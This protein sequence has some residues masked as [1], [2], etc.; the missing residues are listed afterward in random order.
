MFSAQSAFHPIGTALLCNRHEI[1]PSG[2]R[3][4]QW[5]VPSDSRG[6]PNV[7]VAN[8]GKVLPAK[9]CG[10]V[11]GHGKQWRF[12]SYSISICLQ[13]SISFLFLLVII[14]LESLSTFLLALFCT[15]NLSPDLRRSKACQCS[16]THDICKLRTPVEQ[17]LKLLSGSRCH[18]R[19][20]PDL[21]C[22]E[23]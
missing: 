17:L 9:Y 16:A 10:I 12:L 8:I 21:H 22:W 5:A 14:I 19:H 6:R 1:Q 7:L 4:Q 20:L 2:A 11:I 23:D 15:Q 13:K 18:S 3:R